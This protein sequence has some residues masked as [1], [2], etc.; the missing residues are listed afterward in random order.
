MTRNAMTR[1]RHLFLP[2]F[3]F[4]FKG[5]E[6]DGCGR[7]AVVVQGTLRCKLNTL[8]RTG[9]TFLGDLPVLLGILFNCSG[10][11]LIII[12]TKVFK[13]N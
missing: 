13:R 10:I 3:L 11:L 5:E 6:Q 9:V 4:F 8:G 1:D 2:F 12:E 7:A